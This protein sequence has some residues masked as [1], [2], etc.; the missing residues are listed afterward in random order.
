[1]LPAA[2]C[3]RKSLRSKG[4]KLAT[5]Q[6]G[7]LQHRKDGSRVCWQS[8]G[9]PPPALPAGPGSCKHMPYDERRTVSSKCPRIARELT[10]EQGG[11]VPWQLSSRHF[12]QRQ[13][14]GRGPGGTVQW[15]HG[16]RHTHEPCSGKMCCCTAAVKARWCEQCSAVQCNAVQGRAGRCKQCK[17][18]W[19]MRQRTNGWGNGGRPATTLIRPGLACRGPPLPPFLHCA[20]PCN[21]RTAVPSALPFNACIRPSGLIPPASLRCTGTALDVCR[22]TTYPAGS[23]CRRHQGRPRVE[24]RLPHGFDA[25]PSG[26]VQGPQGQAAQQRSSGQKGQQADTAHEGVKEN[27]AL[28]LKQQQQQQ[29]V[30]CA[31]LHGSSRTSGEGGRFPGTWQGGGIHWLLPRSQAPRQGDRAGMKPCTCAAPPPPH[32]PASS[33]HPPA[34]HQWAAARRQAAQQVGLAGVES[35]TIRRVK[36]RWY[37]R[38]CLVRSCLACLIYDVAAGEVKQRRGRAAVPASHADG[39]TAAA[40]HSMLVQRWW[41]PDNRCRMIYCFHRICSTRVGN[42]GASASPKRRGQWYTRCPAHRRVDYHI[43]Y[44][45][46]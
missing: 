21:T 6:A 18:A 25:P 36:R 13:H 8:L 12:S 37:T 31:G 32:C 26:G 10:A 33:A 27:D 23:G 24:P 1:M 40:N 15:Q 34:A 45:V 17:T 28:A 29:W 19:H 41:L 42:F 5:P 14:H 38:G 46:Y 16:L 2:G 43:D 7:C 20:F 3:R 30:G 22:R 35:P 11:R 44:V 39:A 4:P 9:Q